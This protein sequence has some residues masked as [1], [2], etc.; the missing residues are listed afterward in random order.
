MGEFN[1]ISDNIGKEVLDRLGY[2]SDVVS[3]SDELLDFVWERKESLESILAEQDI[4]LQDF[5]AWVYGCSQE[6]GTKQAN[7]EISEYNVRDHDIASLQTAFDAEVVGGEKEQTDLDPIRYVAVDNET[8][9]ILGYISF[10]FCDKSEENRI[11]KFVYLDE[12]YVRPEYR[13][14]D[15]GTKL[16]DTMIN[17]AKA[18]SDEGFHC[19]L[20]DAFSDAYSFFDS[21]GY[22]DIGN[23]W[24]NAYGHKF[25]ERI[26]SL[27]AQG[28]SILSEILQEEDMSEEYS[29]ASGF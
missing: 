13:K 2:N 10:A 14:T 23:S 22:A 21:L 8:G 9:E 5:T 16:H 18:W 25:Y 12:L 17:H 28:R 1:A 24:S 29:E 15:I 4:A 20:T 6:N 7:I 27:D 26:K 3:N 19:I 11:G